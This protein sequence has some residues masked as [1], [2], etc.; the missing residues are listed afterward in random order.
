MAS[1]PEQNVPTIRTFADDFAAAQARADA[2]REAAP[3][4]PTT[5]QA[6]IAPTDETPENIELAVTP[7]SGDEDTYLEVDVPEVHAAE[8]EDIAGDDLE[9]GEIVSEKKRNKFRL[10]PAIGQSMGSWFK[11]KKTEL[12]AEPEQPTIEDPSKRAETISSAVGTSALPQADD[13]ETVAERVA[14]APKVSAADALQ[15]TKA[16]ELPTPQWSSSLSATEPT[17]TPAPATAHST[18]PV[19]TPPEPVLES[20]AP[21]PVAT[22]EVADVPPVVEPAPTP[23][24]KPEP[25]PEP[26]P[27]PAPEPKPTPK[28]TA[29]PTPP[30]AEAKEE[31]AS[32]YRYRATPVE[33]PPRDWRSW[34]VVAAVVIAAIALGVV[35][36]TWVFQYL[37]AP[38]RILAPEVPSAITVDR[39]QAVAMQ[40]S[41]DALLT[42][43]RQAIAGAG[44]GVTQVYPIVATESDTTRPAS[45]DEFL[46]VVPLSADGSFQRNITGLTIIGVK[47]TAVGIIIEFTSFETALGGMYRWESG[48]V[49][50]FGPL[51]GDSPISQFT[52]TASNNRDIRVANRGDGSELLYTFIDR[53]TL[54]I[55]TDRRVIGEVVNRRK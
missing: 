4:E 38:D 49:R 30:E 11:D 16:E 2:P 28:P 8:N 17:P 37:S 43:L 45:I 42:S 48:L 44:G 55:A 24:P 53:N 9:V 18:S 36:S 27:V 1:K 51:L 54:L 7:P 35:V 31:T 32:A 47:Q 13:Y 3:D 12:T 52:D 46:T 41:G 34:V 29:P 26:I 22:P 20:E 21:T 6:K 5:E 19:A 23:T 33:A 40:G 25:T 50:D 14:A 10:F 39:T 15:V